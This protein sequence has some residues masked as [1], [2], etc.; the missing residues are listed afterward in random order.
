MHKLTIPKKEYSAF[1]E[2]QREGKSEAETGI[3][4]MYLFYDLP[5]W[6]VSV[7]ERKTSPTATH[8]RGLLRNSYSTGIGS[9]YRYLC[10]LDTT[11]RNS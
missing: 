5:T 9:Q 1:D 8:I 4:Y 10:T 11:F 3:E 6:Q 7:D 2:M